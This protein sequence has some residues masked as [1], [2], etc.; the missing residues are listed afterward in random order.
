[1]NFLE[2]LFVHVSHSLVVRILAN[3]A[4]SPGSN[5]GGGDMWHGRGR[6]METVGHAW[7]DKMCGGNQVYLIIY[8]QKWHFNLLKFQ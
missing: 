6:T 5:P 4:G 7:C 1:M 8:S 2:H 3:G